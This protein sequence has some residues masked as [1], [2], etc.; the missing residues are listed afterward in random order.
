MLHAAQD[1]ENVRLPVSPPARL[2]ARLQTRSA[3]ISREDNSVSIMKEAVR[4]VAARAG[5]GVPQRHNCRQSA[6]LAFCG[7]LLFF[8]KLKEV[9]F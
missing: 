9:I 3:R 7:R 5:S 2:P 1:A 8:Q 6:G 4:S